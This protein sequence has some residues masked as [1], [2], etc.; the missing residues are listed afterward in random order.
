MTPAFSGI[1][2]GQVAV[3]D[4][5]GGSCGIT[6]SSGKGS[7]Q[8][9]SITAGARS[10]TATYGGDSNFNTSVGTAAQ[11]VNAASTT[12]AMTSMAPNPATIG[13]T[14]TVNFVVAVV[15]PGA[16]TTSGNVS[17]SNG[18]G[19]SCVGALSG[20][21]GSCQLTPATTGTQTIV[22]TFTSANGNYTGSTSSGVTLQV[23]KANSAVTVASSPNPAT[24]AQALT[25][26]VAVTG[27][28]PVPTGTVSVTDS[29]GASC[30]ITLSAGKGSCSLTPK[31]VGP[32]TITASYAGDGNY[33]SSSG[34]NQQS[35]LY[36]FTGFYTPLGPAGTYSGSFG[37]GKVIPVKW[38]LTNSNSTLITSLST[39]TKMTAF[40]NGAPVNG[41]CA[42][43]PSGS[44]LVLYLPTSGAAGKSTFRFSTNQ[45]VFNWDTS[46]ADPFGTGCFTLLLQIN[47]GSSE[48]TSLQIQ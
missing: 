10:L 33:N 11:T 38:T 45:F 26:S 13:Q 47:D 44:S 9:A 29:T 32:D 1:P 43:V 8:L 46:S 48:L 41:T 36:K 23:N 22:A 3:S 39:L 14:V 15:A 25:V 12:T 24:L 18:A 42:I 40:F 35:V 7:C 16:G 17:V 30:S 20:G 5:A 2:T 34:S 31:T 19:A 27:S 21:A 6:L 4:G 28:G 37:L